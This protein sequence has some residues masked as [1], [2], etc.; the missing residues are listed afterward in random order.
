[1]WQPLRFLAGR[2]T[3]RGGVRD[4]VPGVAWWWLQATELLLA[5]LLLLL[6]ADATAR[7]RAELRREAGGAAQDPAR[8]TES[9]AR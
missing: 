9:P 2:L 1:M 8:E 3:V 6:P 7:E 4:G 5:H